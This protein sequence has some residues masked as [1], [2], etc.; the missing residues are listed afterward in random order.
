EKLQ[1]YKKLG[2]DGVQFHDDDAVPEIGSKSAAQ[3]EREAKEMHKTLSDAGL[4]VEIIAPRLWEDARG[5]DGGFT[6]ND[7]KTRQWALDRSKRTID[8]AHLV[9]CDLFIFWYAREGTYIREAKNA[10]DAYKRL[11]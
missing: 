6:A 10:A 1:Q 8:I 5:I 9:K 7:A 11:L 3:V 2:F 4:V